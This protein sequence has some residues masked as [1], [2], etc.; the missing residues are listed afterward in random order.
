MGR[1]GGLLSGDLDEEMI[2][3]ESHGEDG[4]A[5]VVPVDDEVRSPA[6]DDELDECE[7]RD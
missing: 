1:Q 7:R 2:V 4:E 6:E 5:E 3:P